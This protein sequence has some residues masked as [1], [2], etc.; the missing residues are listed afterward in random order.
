M[1]DDRMERLRFKYQF[2]N[3]WHQIEVANWKIGAI[4]VKQLRGCTNTT[5][6]DLA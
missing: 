6:D 2:Q 4:T 5:K 3:K 1:I